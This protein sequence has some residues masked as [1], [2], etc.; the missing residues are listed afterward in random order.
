MAKQIRI[1]VEGK[2]YDV[3]VEVV[4]ESA[5]VTNIAAAAPAPV[6]A[7]PVAAAPAPAPA[8]AAAPRPAAAGAGDVL[9]PI[10][11]TVVSVDVK[12]GQKV[13]TGDKVLTLEAMK[14]NNIVGATAAGT[15]TAI[16]VAVGQSVQEGQPLL[17]VG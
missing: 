14:M 17:S 10:A 2:T 15:V 9:C 13:N 8:P 4:G 5:T 7:A 12:V 11:G 1:T 6:A 16:H 3:T